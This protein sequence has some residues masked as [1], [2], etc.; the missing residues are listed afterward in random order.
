MK[1]N[2]SKPS[3]YKP[4]SPAVE[5]AAQVLLCLGSNLNGDM[6]LTEI[7]NQVGIHKSKGFSILNALGQYDIVT[8]NSETKTYSLG[9]ALMPL[10]RKVT[11]KMD[12]PTIARDHLQQL[13]EET[14]SSVLL[15]IVSNDQLYIAGKYDGSKL[16]SLT[17]RQYQSLHITHGAH[18]K[19]IFAFLN[20]HEKQA[21]MDAGQL[22]FHG[23]DKPLDQKRL[24]Q[25]LAMCQ[26]NGYAID[27][28]ELTP[29]TRAVS[30]PIFDHTNKIVAAIVAAGTFPETLFPSHG[31]KTVKTARKISRQA[32][33]QFETIINLS[34]AD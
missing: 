32:G 19:A 17:I 15:G 26:K 16:L 12:I 9:P 5:Q 28:G 13:A 20:E 33:A 22:F 24:A 30:A 21:I 3:N 6:R 1:T 14:Q 4:A 25:E 18:G 10:G 27:N 29:G 11:E 7:C 23:S 8:K 2:K 34:I 31:K